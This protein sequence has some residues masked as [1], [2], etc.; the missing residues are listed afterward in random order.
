VQE[1]GND[2]RLILGLKLRNLRLARQE[3]L[4]EVAARA[5]LSVSY[6]SELEQGKKYPKP[7]ML[8]RLA[9]AL[10]VAYDDLV[11]LKVTEELSPLK[12]AVS[13]G[14]L[15]EF[16]FELFGVDRE[17][18]VRLIAE[19]PDKTG[20]LIQSL[21][22]IG[23]SYDVQVEHFLLSALRSY[24]QMHANYFEDL[25]SAATEFRRTRGWAVGAPVE[26]EA[27][28]EFLVDQWGFVIDRDSLVDNPELSG[29][30]SVFAPGSPP[31]IHLNRR[32]LPVQQAFILAREVGYRI[33]GLAERVQTSSSIKIES[34]AQVLNNF[35]ASYFAGALLMDRTTLEPALEKLFA[36]PA[37][38]SDEFLRIMS[39][40]RATPEMFLYRLTE[41]V[42]QR[43]GL[44][45]LF[46]MRFQRRE[47]ESGVALTKV[48]NLSGVPVPYGLGLKE[49]YCR[50]W[51]G[52]RL[53]ASDAPGSGVLVE[54]LRFL[55]QDVEFIVLS[56]G[57]TL[58]LDRT[59]RSS[60]SIGFLLEERCREVLR[61]WQDPAI[62]RV[63]VNLTCERCPLSAAE[64]TD[65]VAPPEI[66]RRQELQRARSKALAEL[67]GRS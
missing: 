43:F 67:T 25:E 50:R 49:H 53:V 51:P 47:E 31:V 3:G 15:R 13:S 39:R 21:V 34:F 64:C 19:T 48:F 29:F 7:E 8:L 26:P 23:R 9:G 20:A 42:P 28:A 17:D 45:K 14:F 63:D 27:L 57:R 30:R 38:E 16:P 11:S 60:V 44:D 52:V 61:F 1:S 2:L 33:L 40:C 5:G 55:A 12:E 41:L 4:R 46:F 54:R 65:R 10:D 36:R 35:R 22:D 32:L 62:A 56:L 18:L 24:Q 37:W 66:V 58:A 59:A 6:L